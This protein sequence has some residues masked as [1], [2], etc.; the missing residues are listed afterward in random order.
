MI[1]KHG[2]QAWFPS[3]AKALINIQE[4]FGQIPNVHMHGNCAKVNI[5]IFSKLIKI[6]SLVYICS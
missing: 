4:W 5:V 6:M 1:Y 3:I 2:D